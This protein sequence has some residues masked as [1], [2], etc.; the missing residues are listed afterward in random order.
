MAQIEDDIN[1]TFPALHVFQSPSGPLFDDLRDLICALVGLDISY[2]EP[3][4]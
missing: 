4:H 1:T 2:R 3:S